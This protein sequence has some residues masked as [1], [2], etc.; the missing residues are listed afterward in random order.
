MG[1]S[2]DNARRSGSFHAQ[3][4]V[5]HRHSDSKISR[6]YMAKITATSA[7]GEPW[8]PTG[9]PKSSSVANNH[10][11]SP[12]Y[13]RPQ[14]S[15]VGRRFAQGPYGPIGLWLGVASGPTF[16]GKASGRGLSSNPGERSK[17]GS[18]PHTNRKKVH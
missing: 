16:P 14:Y 9:R 7:T 17:L 15:S 1:E 13:L 6:F 2:V 11:M 5:S 18:A 4:T 10:D 8:R 12:T 3:T